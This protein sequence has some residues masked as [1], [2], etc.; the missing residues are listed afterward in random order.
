MHMGSMRAA[1]LASLFVAAA[2]A[3]PPALADQRD[4]FLAG[5]TIDCPGCDL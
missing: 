5:L 1:V 3:G 2:F 4:D